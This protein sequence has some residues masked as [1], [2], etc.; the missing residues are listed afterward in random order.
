MTHITLEPWWV[1][2]TETSPE[3]C[4]FG[5]ADMDVAR[6]R[7]APSPKRLAKRMSTPDS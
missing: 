7:E 6:A 3:V 2:G 5:L 1:D 4:L